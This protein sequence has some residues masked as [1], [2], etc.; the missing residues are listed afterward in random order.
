MRSNRRG[1]NHL[2]PNETDPELP[3]AVQI[4]PKQE[5]VQHQHGQQVSQNAIGDE[6]AAR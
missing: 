2:S 4:H 1:D 3:E 5:G 6:R